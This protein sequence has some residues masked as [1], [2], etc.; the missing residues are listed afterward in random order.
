M[1]A[2]DL[3][4]SDWLVR[5]QRDVAQAVDAG[6]YADGDASYDKACGG[7][8]VRHGSGPR[9]LLARLAGSRFAPQSSL[10]A[11]NKTLRKN[12][13][14]LAQSLSSNSDCCGSFCSCSP[15]LFDCFILGHATILKHALI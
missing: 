3:L 2:H 12:L 13:G 15:Q 8:E 4:E 7:Y 11:I 9:L 10:D 14:P 6:P 1:S 5:R